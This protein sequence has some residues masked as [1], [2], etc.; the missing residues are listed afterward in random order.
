M[1]AP[2]LGYGLGLCPKHDI[3]H[4][5]KDACLKLF[6]SLPPSPPP[7]LSLSL[8][9]SLSLLSYDKH[10][11]DPSDIINKKSYLDGES[12]LSCHFYQG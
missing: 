4:L 12:I 9:L 2:F 6:L 1:M 5:Y 8:S 11:S 3:L 10:V 7:P